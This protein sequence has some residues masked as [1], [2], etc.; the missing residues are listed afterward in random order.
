MANDSSGDRAFQAFLKRRPSHLLVS[1]LNYPSDLAEQKQVCCPTQVALVSKD[2]GSEA[3]PRAPCAIFPGQLM[4]SERI[5]DSTE[6][7]ADANPPGV[8]RGITQSGVGRCATFLFG[9]MA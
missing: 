3:E 1:D 8:P 2:P 4:H 6:T 9:K 7:K 5:H